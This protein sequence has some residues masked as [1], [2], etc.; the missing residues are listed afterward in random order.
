MLRVSHTACV[1]LYLAALA[2]CAC[3]TDA[4]AERGPRRESLQPKQDLGPQ[5]LQPPW[6]PG[7]DTELDTRRC[8]GERDVM[9][10]LGDGEPAREQELNGFLDRQPDEIHDHGAGVVESGWGL[11]CDGE[12]RDSDRCLRIGL[13]LCTTAISSIAERAVRVVP[14][15]ISLWPAPSEMAAILMSRPMS[16][17][18]GKIGARVATAAVPVRSSVLPRAH[19]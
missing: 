11:C 15:R 17:G 18:R 7:S 2:V 13:R 16:F 19:S 9:F 14:L 3:G 8:D 10:V 6:V 4:H 12:S 1:S 5:C